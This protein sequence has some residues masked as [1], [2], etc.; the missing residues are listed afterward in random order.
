MQE[1]ETV[2]YTQWKKGAEEYGPEAFV[3]LSFEDLFKMYHEELAD[4][5]NYGMMAFVKLR[6]MEEQ[7]RASGFDLTRK[8]A[9]EGT[10]HGDT[11]DTSTPSFGSELPGFLQ[12]GE[13][14]Q[15][16]GQRRSG[17]FS[18]RLGDLD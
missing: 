1:F 9:G 15:D 4:I 6:L 5:A 7:L 18:S 12:A 11:P 14:S 2:R 17:G 13:G 3:D 16:P 8:P 10:E